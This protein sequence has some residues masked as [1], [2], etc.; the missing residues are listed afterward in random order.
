[1]DEELCRLLSRKDLDALHV[2]GSALLLLDTC[3]GGNSS[4][5]VVRERLET[6]ADFSVDAC[7]QLRLIP[8]VVAT[9]LPHEPL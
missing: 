1:M 7:D 9:E 8:V 5:N 3:E 6:L 2:I 4:S